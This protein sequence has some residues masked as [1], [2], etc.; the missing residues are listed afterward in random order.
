MANHLDYVIDTPPRHRRHP[1]VCGKN[2]ETKQVFIVT[3]A[4]KKM[5]PQAWD[6]KRKDEDMPTVNFCDWCHGFKKDGEGK[7]KTIDQRHNYVCIKCSEIYD[8]AM[9]QCSLSVI[10]ACKQNRPELPK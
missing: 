5:R 1:L 4:C 3:F 2:S 6:Q 10:A 8:N 9:D 7:L